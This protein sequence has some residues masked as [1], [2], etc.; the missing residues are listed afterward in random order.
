MTQPLS[1]VNVVTSD[2]LMNGM[3]TLMSSLVFGSKINFT[4]FFTS[5]SAA[6]SGMTRP[7]SSVNSLTASG[8]PAVGGTY[9]IGRESP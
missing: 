4:S 1:M 5:S 2:L 9:I 6:F 7:K 3:V 8:R